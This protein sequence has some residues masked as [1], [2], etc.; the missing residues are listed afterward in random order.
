MK[1]RKGRKDGRCRRTGK[2]DRKDVNIVKMRKCDE[3][4]N[5]EKKE[6]RTLFVIEGGKV[7]LA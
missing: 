3:R 2:R 5:D 4:S 7:W 1:N 6:K